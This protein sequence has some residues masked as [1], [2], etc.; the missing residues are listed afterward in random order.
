MS[1]GTTWHRLAAAFLLGGLAVGGL[2][3]IGFWPLMLLALAG[4]SLLIRREASALRG[5]L[6]GWCFGFGYF[7]VGLHWI[8][9][10]FSV[11]PERFAWAAVPAVG[12]LSAVMAVYAALAV[13]MTV[14]V[15]PPGLARALALPAFWTLSE[16]MRAMLFSGFPWN[17]VGYAIAGNDN[18]AQLAA[19][20][21]VHALGFV[22]VLS[23]MLGAEAFVSS[24]SRRWVLGGAGAGILAATWIY[25]GARLTGAAVETTA[26]TL[27][28]VQAD[29]PQNLKWRPD[30]RERILARYVELSAQPP[31]GVRRPSIILWPETALPVSVD[32]ASAVI[33]PLRG[34]VA[35]DG[36]LMLGVS[37]LHA[38]TATVPAHPHNSA[39]AVD[40]EGRIVAEYDKARLVPFGEFMPLRSYLPLQKLTVGSQDFVP[41]PGPRRWLLPGMPPVQ[42]LICYEAIFPGDQP[43]SADQQRPAWLLNLTNDAWFGRS[44]GPYQ[45]LAMARLRAVERGLPL[46]RVANGGVS[47]V[48]DGYG[49]IVASLP[50]DAVGVLDVDLPQSLAVRPLYDHYGDQPVWILVTVVIAAITASQGFSTDRAWQGDD[51]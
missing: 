35:S 17:L 28:L 45:H 46:V 50:I 34:L 4:L 11:D 39:V 41:G 7:L 16:L 30:Q 25:G 9:N 27:R 36:L 2:P 10:A 15:A 31:T 22:T 47:A 8:G 24:G 44:A 26:T 33:A 29:I 23:A 1:I 14:L 32:Q 40:S 19:L 49:R 51:A 43:P 21:G 20:G 38:E 13:A 37:R 12:F 42:P 6:T 3:P 5:A 18:M 48:T